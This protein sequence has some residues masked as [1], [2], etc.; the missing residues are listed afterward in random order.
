MNDNIPLDALL[1]REQLLNNQ[2]SLDAVDDVQVARLAALALVGECS[3]LDD[4][5]GRSR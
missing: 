5:V 3:K 1:G 4:P 2:C